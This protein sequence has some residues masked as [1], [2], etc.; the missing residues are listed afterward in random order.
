MVNNK[1]DTLP[2]C[3]WV[4]NSTEDTNSHDLVYVSAWAISGLAVGKIAIIEIEPN[5]RIIAEIETTTI[6][7]KLLTATTFLPR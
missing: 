7:S 3:V 5:S 2:V 6:F 4:Q 1:L